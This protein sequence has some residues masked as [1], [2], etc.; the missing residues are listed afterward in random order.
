MDPS[1]Q[2]E[3]SETGIAGNRPIGSSRR[4]LLASIDYRPSSLPDL[5][6]DLAIEHT[7]KRPV[8]FDNSLDA[9]ASTI[10]DLGARYRFTV[11]EMRGTLRLRALNL[12]DTFA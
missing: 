9:P 8:N 4:R 11:G 5:F 12:F 10:V 2:I 1:V 7:C 3:P 6:V